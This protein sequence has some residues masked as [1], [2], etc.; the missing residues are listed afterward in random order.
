MQKNGKKKQVAVLHT[1]KRIP[2]A[3]QL[4][5]PWVLFILFIWLVEN[6]RQQQEDPDVLPVQKSSTAKR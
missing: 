3:V 1:F 6:P 4:L 5:P 2:F